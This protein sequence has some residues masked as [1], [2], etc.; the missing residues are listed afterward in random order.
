[1]DAA[2][3]E[4]LQLEQFQVSL[5]E[6]QSQDGVPLVN[7]IATANVRLKAER[8]VLVYQEGPGVIHTALILTELEDLD[9]TQGLTGC[10]FYI[11]IG[12]NLR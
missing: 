6:L 2:L 10:T 11:I 5:T 9:I 8:W 3:S 4:E 1:M 7:L 12:Y